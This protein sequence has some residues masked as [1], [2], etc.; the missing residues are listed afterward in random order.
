MA[1]DSRVKGR[2]YEY[3]VRDIFTKTLG[4][5]F[6]RTP[7]SG[8]LYYAKGDVFSPER[9]DWPYIIE[10]KH[11][12]E[13]SFNNLLSAK[14]NDLWSFWQQN[15]DAIAT[16][17]KELPNAEYKS[18]VAFRWNRSKNYAMWDS[19]IELKSQMNVKAH[20]YNVKIGLLDDWL[21]EIKKVFSC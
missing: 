13:L 6:E 21:V 19:E 8:A 18:V 14:S 7:M 12:K 1:V 10:C 5:K 4:F 2:T 16:A 11:Y 3:K 9:P 20:G 17:K 15:L